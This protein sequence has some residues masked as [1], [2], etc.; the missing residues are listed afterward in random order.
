MACAIVIDNQRLAAIAYC[1]SRL[2]GRE[3][4][5]K[6]SFFEKKSQKTFVYFALVSG[7]ELTNGSKSQKFFG[8]F[9]QK[10]TPC[11]P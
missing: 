7:D 6:Q 8:S 11:L 9:F 3:G 2:G 10:R 1:P 4:K 5:K